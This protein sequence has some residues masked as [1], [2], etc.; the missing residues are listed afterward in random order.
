M[1]RGRNLWWVVA[2][3]GVVT[4]LPLLALAVKSFTIDGHLT[5]E[6]YR[7]VLDTPQQWRLFERSAILASLVTA[8]TLPAGLL[9]G[10]VLGKSDLPLRRL[11]TLLLLI[12]LLVPPYIWAVGWSDLFAP[13]GLFAHLFGQEAAKVA[14]GYL[15]GLYGCVFILSCVYLPIPLILTMALLRSVPRSFEEAGRMVAGWPAVLRHITLP[16][17]AP[18]LLIAGVLVFLLAFG[19]LTVPNYLRYDLYVVE[20]FTH[21]SAFY[22]FSAATASAVPIVVVALALLLLEERVRLTFFSEPLPPTSDI[23]M[24]LVP[25]G[26][27]RWPVAFSVALWVGLTA[28]VPTSAL[29][30]EAGGWANYVEAIQR[31]GSSIGHTLLFAAAGATLL[32]VLGFFTG[33]LVRRRALPLWRI[34]DATTL[35]LFALPGSVVGIALVA[36]WNTP[37]GGFVYSTPLIILLGYAAKYLVLP[38]RITAAQLALIPP[39]MEEAA[40]LVGASWGQRILYIV[41]PL[42]WRGLLAGWLVAYLFCMRDTAITMTLYP[43]GADTLSVRIFTLMANGS[44][45]LIAALCMV[46]VV[47]TLVPLLF[48]GTLLRGVVR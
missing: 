12:P 48:L 1:E 9:L 28:V 27:Y 17:V 22:D 32:S 8:V 40:Q 35:F 31:A 45:E 41:A 21:F 36:L 43:P 29:A 42:A 10:M 13:T 37:L 30:M 23:P 5:L 3:S 20:S 7:R 39:S 16:L 25:L 11:F 18:A 19:E 46:T 38:S 44:P 6:A 33:Y 4:F 24:A 47:L 34:V 26:R 15:F 2:V 14:S